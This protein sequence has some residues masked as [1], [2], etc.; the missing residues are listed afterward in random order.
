MCGTSLPRNVFAVLVAL[1]GFAAMQAPLGAQPC[2]AG[3][4]PCVK[5]DQ[6]N[7]ARDGYNSA[8]SVLTS[9]NLRNGTTL[10]ELA[11]LMVDTPPPSISKANPIYVQP[12]YIAGISL[13]PNAPQQSL[14]NCANLIV[15]SQPACN[16]LV[17][18]TLYGSIW[19]Y[20]AD[21]GRTI[22]SRLA[23]FNDCGPNSTVP[24]SGQ[25]GIGSLPFAGIVSTPVIDTNLS[26]PAM[27]LTDV[28][29]DSQSMVHWF[30]HEVDITNQFQD[31]P[32]SG[33]P[34]EIAGSN[35]G[36]TFSAG[37]VLQ[38]PALLEVQDP[39]GTPAN[40]IYIGFG[41]AVP[42]APNAVTG[43]TYPY[44][45]WLFGYSTSG[46]NN[47]LIQDFV[48]NASGGGSGSATPACNTNAPL[49]GAAGCQ[50][51][52]FE[53]QPN[54]CGHGGGIWMSGRGPAAGTSKGIAHAFVGVGNGGYQTSAANWGSSIV[55]FDSS[56]SA[57]ISASPSDSFTPHGGPSAPFTAPIL[58]G[59]SCPTTPGGTAVKCPYTFETMNENDWDMS[60]SGILL[61]EDAKKTNWLLTVDKSGAGYMLNQDNLGGFTQND[62]GNHFPFIAGTSPC[63]TL[64]V[65]SDECDRVVSLA[66]YKSSAS[67]TRYVYYWPYQQL[68]TGLQFSN[69]VVTTGVGTIATT[70]GGPPY[71]TVNL[72]TACAPQS[73]TTPCFNSQM[74]TGDTL[75]AASQSQTVT[76][77]GYSTLT[78]TP[79]FS[80]PVNTSTWTFHGLFI[81]PV[82]ANAPKA[83]TSVEYPGGAV[84]V[85]ANGGNS[86]VVWGLATIETAPANPPTQVCP[87]LTAMLNAY[88]APTLT[89][90]WSTYNTNNPGHCFGPC[91]AIT[92][93]PAA[94]SCTIP[95]STF[96]LPTI[97][98]GD[99]FIPTYQITYTSTNPSC[100]YGQPC[101]GLV[102]YCGTG[103]TACN[104][105]WQQ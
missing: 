86:G 75:V 4:P 100:S 92:P 8:E 19:A 77:T 91:F 63:W 43:Q 80:S 17:A 82:Y 16:M 64:G 23:L 26:P 9:G 2:A 79:G 39:S 104:G 69:N 10:T 15:N 93:P 5:T 60:V 78:V 66:S 45:G 99:V 55:S 105:D 83:G 28:C 96:G 59:S 34:L 54:W 7:T 49:C 22:F 46:P 21:T 27:F 37:E 76:S 81:E 14:S 31:V 38:R 90:I 30:L 85:T 40:V 73:A 44:H 62:T 24:V 101:S 84:E 20:N 52:Q 67:G 41:S 48:F 88:D 29:L 103:T 51:G 11:P 87:S 33:S 25:G 56:T 1:S 36:D 58:A 18:V 57:G 12:L 3:G 65:R 97:V 89:Q 50:A 74:V 68:V 61:F 98:N 70:G 72:L 35:G 13:S 102:V 71:T 42:E 32:N 47:Q 6:Y 95:A 53:N 94:N